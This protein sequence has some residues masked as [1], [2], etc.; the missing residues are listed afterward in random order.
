MR[1]V[2]V[3]SQVIGL[4]R[5]HDQGVYRLSFRMSYSGILSARAW[6]RDIQRC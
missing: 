2:A 4:V 6:G 3:L 1:L 5:R